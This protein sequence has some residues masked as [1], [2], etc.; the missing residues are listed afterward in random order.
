[1]QRVYHILMVSG[2]YPDI[3]KHVL[4]CLDLTSM[5]IRAK[6]V[7]TLHGKNLSYPGRD[8]I[9]EARNNGYVQGNHKQRSRL[10]TPRTGRYDWCVQ[11]T[12]SANRRI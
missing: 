9:E 6:L 5:L 11:A 3:P 8:Q 7:G 2:K 10:Q 4:F 1:M 12:A